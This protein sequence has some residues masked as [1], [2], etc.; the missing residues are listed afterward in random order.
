M[1]GLGFGQTAKEN[2]FFKRKL[3]FFVVRTGCCHFGY[4]PIDR[5]S[6]RSTRAECFF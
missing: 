5:V 6:F 3:F 4:N 2:L 1:G